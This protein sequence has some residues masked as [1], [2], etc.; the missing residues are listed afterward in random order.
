M[1]GPF[2]REDGDEATNRSVPPTRCATCEGDRFVTVRLR[3]QEQTAWMA[4]HGHRPNPKEF[5]EE[6]APCPDCNPIQVEYYLVG[7]HRFRSMDA[8][9]TR[10]AMSE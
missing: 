4:E 7:G 5:H 8:A 6:M 2:D 3:S 10:A 9:A 1:T